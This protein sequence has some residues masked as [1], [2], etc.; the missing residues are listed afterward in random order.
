MK[1][2]AWAFILLFST[3]VVPSDHAD[4][5][6]QEDIP[7]SY[8]NIFVDRA[9]RPFIK[10]PGGNRY[11]LRSETP[12]YTLNMLRGSPRG[13]ARGIDFHFKDTKYGITLKT[14]KLY[15]GFIKHG[16]GRYNLP[17]YYKE[18]S[19]I[20]KGRASINI[21]DKLGGRYDMIDW[22]TTRRGTLGYRVVDEKGN[23]LYDGKIAFVGKGPFRVD[24]CIIEGPFVHKLRPHSLTVSFET[25]RPAR[26]EVI[27]NGKVFSDSGRK[28][29]HEIPVAG[30]S[31][32]TLYP[33]TATTHEGLQ[34]ESHEIRTAPAPGSR[35]PFT[36]A[37]TS[38]SRAGQGGGERDIGNVN[39]YM[40]K[41]IMA[42]VCERNAAF[43]QFTGDMIDGYAN[44]IPEQR[45]E[46]GNWKRAIEPWASY[47]PVVPAFGNHESLIY[48]W[49][50]GSEL[51]MVCDRF[52]YETDSA[53]AV[54]ADVFVNPEN[55]PESEDGAAYDPDPNQT[56]FPSYREN[57]FY[58][59]YDNVAMVTLNSDYWYSYA[60]PEKTYIGGNLHGYLMDNQL[61]WLVRT[62]ARLEE[63]SSIDFVFVT[64]HT[65]AF[66]SAGHVADAMWCEG[67]NHP[68]PYV[69]GRPVPDGIIERRDAH[70]KILLDHP[71]VVAVL[72]GDDHNFSMLRVKEGVD[73]YD[74][75]RYSPRRPLR[76]TRP[77][78]H[79]NNGAAGAPYHSREWTPWYDH[80]EGFTTQNAVVFF[81]IDGPRVE[82]E[83]IN[84]NTLEKIEQRRLLVK[85]TGTLGR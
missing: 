79:I 30:L 21:A 57:V 32:D 38:D 52:P 56:D 22:K 43:L 62:L 64:H 67:S 24:T 2:T 18:F 9:G 7:A 37:Y 28:L 45:V 12:R 82:I 13:T 53:E 34:R 83:V 23:V 33:Y 50:D 19:K 85:R 11:D 25:N 55:G 78:W 36:F 63:D 4:A 27:I 76:L 42:L 81:H 1:I 71:K 72:T 60:L 49:E 15:Y 51:G 46:Y 3:L 26:G 77:I 59:I 66:P 44:S 48:L 70:W 29:K 84:P 40:M 20:S 69:A 68:R 16:D 8:T 39:A 6:T 14:G 54:F 74:K 31:P 5:L 17:V 47:L 80:L 75:R 65:P 61:A 58:Y 41:K 73:I 35:K 10:D